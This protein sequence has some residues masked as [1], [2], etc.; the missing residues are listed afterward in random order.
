[1]DRCPENALLFDTLFCVKK[2]GLQMNKLSID[3]T[4][5]AVSSLLVLRD[6]MNKQLVKIENLLQESMKDGSDLSGI[7]VSIEDISEART[8]ILSGIASITETL[9]W[10]RFMAVK[11]F[12]GNELE[13][14]RTLPNIVHPTLN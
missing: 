13:C 6:V 2:E 14:V 7:C 1:M 8:G 5:N 9:S 3:V 12:E 10:V 11:D 4:D